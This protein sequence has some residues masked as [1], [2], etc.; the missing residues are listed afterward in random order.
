M[1]YVYRYIDLEDN[2]VKYVGIVWGEN[3]TLYQ[4]INEHKLYDDWTINKNFKIEY[5][6]TN[7]KTRTDAEYFEAH[8]IS[9]YKTDKWFNKSKSGWGVSTFLLSHNEEEWV[10][11]KENDFKKEKKRKTNEVKKSKTENRDNKNYYNEY[12]KKLYE[13][14]LQTKDFINE[15]ILNGLNKEKII[16]SNNRIKELFNYY[17]RDIPATLKEMIGY[18]IEESNVNIHKKSYYIFPIISDIKQSAESI[19]YK[20]MTKILLTEDLSCEIK[21]YIIS[22]SYKEFVDY[23]KEMAIENQLNYL[24]KILK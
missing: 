18:L 6:K 17:L 7:I 22:V 15:Y 10:E 14:N 4:R 16:I 21:E 5:T 3:R 8:Y 2:I 12:M 13:Y 9:L 19:E 1:A 11:Y 24:S 23:I 20:N